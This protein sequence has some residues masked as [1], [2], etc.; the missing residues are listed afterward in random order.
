MREEIM[1]ALARG[2]C[3]KR[4]E[5]KELDAELIEDMTDK[6]MQIVDKPKKVKLEFT[7]SEYVEKMLQKNYDLRKELAELKQ[8]ITVENIYHIIKPKTLEFELVHMENVA[9]KVVD[10][11]LL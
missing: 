9:K 4:N 7:S 2:Y 1:Q 11:L 3:T 8:K 6:V 5:K 10:Y